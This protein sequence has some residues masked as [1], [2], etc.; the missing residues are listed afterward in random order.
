MPDPLHKHL[1][2]LAAGTKYE[3]SARE[4]PKSRYSGRSVD[5]RPHRTAGEGE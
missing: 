1:L 2:L 4:Q 5:L 3:Q